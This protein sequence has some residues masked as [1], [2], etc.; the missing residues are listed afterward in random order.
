M[1]NK[2]SPP[3]PS[4]AP[5]Q[6]EVTRLTNI[7]MG[8][9]GTT[10]VESALTVIC[11]LAGQLVA[12]LSEGKPSGVKEYSISLAENI[13]FAA[14]TKLLHDDEKKRKEKPCH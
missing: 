9:I 11:N 14:I 4:G 3:P 13:R 2:P 10:D 8:Q 7:I 1:N 12:S 6:D 5:I